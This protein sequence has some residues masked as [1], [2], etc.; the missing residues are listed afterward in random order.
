MVVTEQMKQKALNELE[1]QKALKELEKLKALK[2]QEEAYASAKWIKEVLWKRKGPN[3]VI[4]RD[5]KYPLATYWDIQKFEE[6]IKQWAIELNKQDAEWL[7]KV[8][9]QAMIDMWLR[10]QEQVKTAVSPK[11]DKIKS[12]AE[13]EFDE[14]FDDAYTIDESKVV[15]KVDDV[16]DSATDVAKVVDK[17]DDVVDTVSD[18]AKV[19][20]KVD[21]IPWAWKISKAA[22]VTNFLKK[23][24][25][26]AKIL[27][28]KWAKLWWKAV[29]PVTVAY[30]ALKDFEWFNEWDIDMS[31]NTFQD[32]WELAEE[33]TRSALDTWGKFVLNTAED[34]VEIWDTIL[35]WLAWGLWQ[36]W[37]I[38]NEATKFFGSDK[39]RE[40]IKKNEVD[41]STL[42]MKAI[43]DLWLSDKYK[44][45]SNKT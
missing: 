2:R 37:D 32:I 39:T 11:K 19:V 28:N 44:K 10:K 30:T 17:T 45:E 12:K 22:K 21:D 33:W 15:D 13:Q 34:A 3:F 42:F 36:M 7:V 5:G 29:M 20:D 27:G 6:L 16:V 38:W 18:V 1:K 43:D 41:Y 31:W 23:N 8:K 14:M 4:V 9:E 40:E 35:K 25:K 24:P 26:I